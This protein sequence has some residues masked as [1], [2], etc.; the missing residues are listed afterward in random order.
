MTPLCKK[1]ER[2]RE[3]KWCLFLTT[4][5]SSVV[6][7]AAVVDVD[8]NSLMVSVVV[9]VTDE[10]LALEALEVTPK[11]CATFNILTSDFEAQQNN[12]KGAD[13]VHFMVVDVVVVVAMI[14]MDTD[15]HWN[16]L[17]I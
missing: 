5:Q 13:G 11:H 1:K 15:G 3:R 9:V 8:D 7:V 16:L 14:S 12:Q 17:F 10:T 6:V 4:S 2:E